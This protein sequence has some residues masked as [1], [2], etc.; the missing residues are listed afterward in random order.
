[1]DKSAKECPELLIW[2]FKD[3]DDFI[4]NA[5][6]VC[7][8]YEKTKTIDHWEETKLK[9]NMNPDEEHSAGLWLV[10]IYAMFMAL[11][12]LCFCFRNKRCIWSKDEKG[13]DQTEVG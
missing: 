9:A 8:N 12:C 3:F 13:E 2:P 4:K 7:P 6:N 10:P 5:K 11:G 1:L